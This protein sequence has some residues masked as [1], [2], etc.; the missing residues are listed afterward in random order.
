[1]SNHSRALRVRWWAWLRHR[2]WLRLALLVMTAS[3]TVAKPYRQL[4]S[5]A[6][7]S[8]CIVVVT[9]AL[10]NNEKREP[11]DDYVDRLSAAMD[12]R[13]YD[14]LLGFS[15]RKV[16]FGDEVWTLTVW[17]DEAALRGFM[18]SGLHREGIAAAPGAIRSLR[19][20]HFRRP[21]NA[22]A[23]SW[24]EALARFD[25]LEAEGSR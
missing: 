15:I 6:P 17:R 9:Y 10:I 13:Q 1:M 11:F 8:D 20:H 5:A 18:Q 14:G 2:A 22:A 19:S 4:S 24:S 7:D 16:L 21:A 23:V 3:C 25:A 12:A